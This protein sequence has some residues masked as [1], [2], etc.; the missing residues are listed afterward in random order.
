MYALWVRDVVP[1][2]GKMS[3]ISAPFALHLSGLFDPLGTARVY[4]YVYV[5]YESRFN[6]CPYPPFPF[7]LSSDTGTGSE[8][9]NRTLVGALAQPLSKQ[10]SQRLTRLHIL[11]PA[12]E[13][14][15]PLIL[16]Y[17]PPCRPLRPSLET[18][19]DMRQAHG[20]QHHLTCLA[21]VRMEFG[22][23]KKFRWE[24]YSVSQ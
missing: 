16:S 23:Q 19:A 18:Y 20:C 12:P 3:D 7:P 6:Q 4:F 15:L 5:R 8:D 1:S 17:V 22:G 14:Y 21:S 10:T 9:S 13:S 11:S 24:A 2:T